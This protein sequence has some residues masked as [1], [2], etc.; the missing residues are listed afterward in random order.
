MILKSHFETFFVYFEINIIT[1]Y[2]V[3][4]NIYRFRLLILFYKF[5][6]VGMKLALI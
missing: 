3:R 5:K 2:Y 6:K 4:R 1:F